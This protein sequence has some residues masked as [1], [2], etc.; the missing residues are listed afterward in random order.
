MVLQ[1]NEAALCAYKSLGFKVTRAL[2]CF[3]L[4]LDA[5]TIKSWAPGSHDYTITQ[6]T[7]TPQFQNLQNLQNWHPSWQNS[8]EAVKAKK[9][10]LLQ[11]QGPA[12][13][14]FA[15]LVYQPDIKQIIQL[16]VGTKDTKLLTTLLIKHVMGLFPEDPLIW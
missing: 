10:T 9:I 16:F 4:E 7:E 5:C 11:A 6:S 2:D 14:T 13:E 8:N 12:Q 1:Q 3:K 15:Y